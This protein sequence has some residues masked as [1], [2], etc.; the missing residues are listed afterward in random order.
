MRQ[1]NNYSL[2]SKGKLEQNFYDEKYYSERM[3]NHIDPYLRYVLLNYVG[4]PAMN[5]KQRK[6]RVLDVGCGIGVY[7]NFFKECGID[8]RGVDF[9][10]EAS[11]ISGQTVATAVALPFKDN[12]FDAILSVHT[13]EHMTIDVRDAFYSECRRVLK[14]NGRIFILTPNGMCPNRFIFRGRWFSDPSHI[15][16]YNPFSLAYSLKRSGFV[17]IRNTFWISINKIKKGKGDIVEY[18][19][20][21]TIFKYFPVLQ[22]LLFFLLY[23]SPLSYIRDVIYMQAEVRK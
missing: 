8:A 3:Y 23:A 4:A 5:G 22:D 18:F 19:G 10:F 20:L 12:N 11:R 21:K 7:I 15:S 16:I 14:N 13:I 17:K 2:R 9:S 6:I 1:K